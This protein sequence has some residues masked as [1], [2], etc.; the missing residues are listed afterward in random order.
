ML[1]DCLVAVGFYF[2][3]FARASQ[4]PMTGHTPGLIPCTRDKTYTHGWGTIPQDSSRVCS[5]CSYYDQ[6][7]QHSPLVAL[8]LSITTAGTIMP[9]RDSYD[10]AEGYV[11]GYWHPPSSLVLRAIGRD[12]EAIGRCRWLPG[13][14]IHLFRK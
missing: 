8:S 10:G 9:Y 3:M 1:S 12:R 11:E 14:Y 5:Q 7:M 2:L 13:R 6:C 4:Q